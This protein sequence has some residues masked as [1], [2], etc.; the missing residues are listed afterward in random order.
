MAKSK[1]IPSHGK[2]SFIDVESV[3]LIN[4]LL[5]RHGRVASNIVAH[6]SWANTDGDLDI[7]DEDN[8]LVGTF[9]AQAKT[10]HESGKLKFVCPTGFLEYC[11]NI[12]PVMLLI[13]D[14]S[15][16][17]VYWLFMDKDAVEK[18]N[19]STT[20]KTKTLN[21]VE[22]QSFNED[23]TEYIAEWTEIFL[24]KKNAVESLIKRVNESL[25]NEIDVS[26]KLLNDFRYSEA[27]SYL[28]E[29][30]EQRW[31][32]ADDNSKFRILTNIAAAQCHLDSAGEG[33]DNFIKAYDF[34]PDLPK[35][36]SNKAMA[37]IFKGE[38]Q[39]AVDQA[40]EVLNKNPIDIQASSAKIQA[41]A[42]S[43]VDFE[44]IVKKVDTTVL[45]DPTVAHA[46]S[47]AAKIL[48]LDDKSIEYLEIAAT[49][50]SDNDPNVLADLGIAI[51]ESVIN[52]DRAARKGLLTPEQTQKVS[53]A[54]SLLQ[55]AWD[56]LPNTEDR[57]HKS[58]WLFDIA[59]G[60][61][62]LGEDC[63]AEKASEELINLVPNND[64]YTK[65]A[66]VI[67]MESKKFDVAEKLFKAMIKNSSD[68][69]ELPVMLVDALRF[70]EKYAEALEL[71]KEYLDTHDVDSELYTDMCESM[72]EILI[73][74]D[75]Y[76]EARTLADELLLSPK[77]KVF[78][79]LFLARL[80]RIE[81]NSESSSRNLE[82]AQLLVSKD[83]PIALVLS[84]AEEAYLSERFDIASVGYAR[85]FNSVSDNSYAQRYLDSLYRSGRY[86]DAIDVAAAIRKQSGTSRYITQFEWGSYLELQD[87]PNARSVLGMYISDHPDD[88]E[89]RLSRAI[90]DLR[91]KKFKELDEY[92]DS[93]INLEGLGLLSEIQLSNL[94]Q[95]RNQHIRTL[96][97]IYD[98][99]RRYPDDADAHSAYVSIFL[100]LENSKEVSELLKIKTVQSNTAL[101]YDGG[102]FLVEATYEP[103]ISK[104][105]I[106]T[107]D[108]KKR[109]YIGKKKGDLIVLS[110]NHL[111]KRELEI[112]E[113]QSKYVFALQDSMKNFER[114]FSERSDL[115]SFNVS[116]DNFDP[117]FKQLDQ[118]ASRAEDIE[119]LYKEGKLTID[120]FAKLVGRNVIEVFYA[121]MT[122]SDLGI[123]VANGTT[124]ETKKVEALLN[125]V[126]DPVI[127]ADI[128]ALATLNLLGIETSEIGLKPLI[129]AQRTKDLVFALTSQHEAIGKKKSMTLYKRN[130]KYIR[131]EV[132]AEEQKQQLNG[133]KK[134]S[135]WID[136]NTAVE[137]LS[138]DQIDVVNDQ[139]VDPEK[140]DDLIDAAQMDTIKLS[141]GENR[142]L[143]SDDLGLRS[144]SGSAFGTNGIWTQPL[145]AHQC[146][147]SL[148]PED[149][150]KRAVVVLIEN[151]YHH[152]AISPQVLMAAA[153]A[154]KWTPRSPLTNAMSAIARPEVITTSMVIVLVNF[155]YDYYRQVTLA[156]KTL[157]VNLVL[158]EATR[159]H[160]KDEVIAKLRAAL[161]AKFK[162]H[163]TALQDIEGTIEAWIS[164]HDLS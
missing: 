60:Y 11:K 44:S 89:A 137:P 142:L 109:G 51:L 22:A 158:S 47:F 61:R 149:D 135:K 96:E 32:D 124:Q 146:D 80:D 36:Q 110:H 69:P 5:A 128:T 3:S 73:Q 79:F 131:H 143:Y 68:L 100:G 74:Q 58:A 164:L 24:N 93:E 134:L 64:M 78:G 4:G 34:Q 148:I 126:A 130:G 120:L 87:L 152:T 43:G 107:E 53:R 88:E 99:R 94:Y 122:S 17:R 30:Q 28:Q 1:N 91:S 23:D 121:L 15:T 57:K 156:D 6:D 35:A 77:S 29:I 95:S 19:Y 161:K 76:E 106:S 71:A 81:Q 92:L 118:T 14:N 10:L 49:K 113:V 37:H 132:S 84:V 151:N 90:I 31:D 112:K 38:Y 52:K 63:Y 160:D 12:Q 116:S 101:I 108:A 104:S 56:R 145:L 127:V 13:A 125:E 42:H 41:L 147:V 159:H 20:A 163:P 7:Q 103:Q 85:V 102:H 26:K 155:L 154:A 55:K 86:K 48:G 98:A 111:S 46:L 97:I 133:L 75:K 153:K 21:L 138:Q 27:L 70:Q 16:R 141:V 150:Y 50:D 25:S 115:M 45:D 18:L 162:L 9:K 129:I 119:K 117:L 140:L 39:S 139:S 114:N 82:Q 66:A 67:A 8:N 54:V 136:R 2:T 59:M 105:E 72:F 40:N 144:L 62:V 65:N 157:V 33:A 123:K 83:A